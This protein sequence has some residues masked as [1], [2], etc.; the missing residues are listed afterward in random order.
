[1]IQIK[2]KADSSLLAWLGYQ[3]LFDLPEPRGFQTTLSFLIFGMFD[4][5]YTH[6]SKKTGV[7]E[8]LEFV[9]LPA[10]H[11]QPSNSLSMIRIKLITAQERLC[12]LFV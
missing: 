5:S 1:L 6:L 7:I 8:Q 2:Y 11:F 4:S 12:C 10:A 3:L 9:Q